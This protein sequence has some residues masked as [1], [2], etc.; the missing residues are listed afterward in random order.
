M[1]EYNHCHVVAN[2]ENSG[3]FND[4]EAIY[5]MTMAAAFLGAAVDGDHGPV[6]G[7]FGWSGKIKC[8]A[9]TR[10]EN[11]SKRYFGKCLRLNLNKFSPESKA[12]FAGE[13][14]QPIETTATNT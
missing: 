9:F 13:C 1:A 4:G 5:N 2:A 7:G 14:V 6:N 12:T 11:G 3:F 8:H 10:S